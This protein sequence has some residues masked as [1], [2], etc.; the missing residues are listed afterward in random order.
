MDEFK[1]NEVFS[2][3]HLLLSYLPKKAML[4]AIVSG[5][6]VYFNADLKLQVAYWLFIL[7]LIISLPIFKYRKCHRKH[8]QLII[9]Y[10]DAYIEILKSELA[11]VSHDDLIDRYWVGL[12]PKQSSS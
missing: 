7:P 3:K 12:E 1:L 11:N 6:L 2:V 4:L 5:I 8:D 10:G 9:E